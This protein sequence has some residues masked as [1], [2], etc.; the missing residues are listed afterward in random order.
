L[1]LTIVTRELSSKTTI[2]AMGINDKSSIRTKGSRDKN[3]KWMT[4]RE[5][6]SKSKRHDQQRFGLRGNVRVERQ[7][8]EA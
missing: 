3:K 5:K 4:K 6:K 7:R 8:Q 1:L 2:V